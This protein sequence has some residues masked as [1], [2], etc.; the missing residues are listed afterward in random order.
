[1]TDE[2]IKA[3]HQLEKIQA[4]VSVLGWGKYTDHGMIDRIYKVIFCDY[5]NEK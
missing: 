1:M 3:K 2:S 4:V 5:P